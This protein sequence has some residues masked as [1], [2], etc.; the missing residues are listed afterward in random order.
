MAPGGDEEVG[1]WKSLFW[2]DAD[3]KMRIALPILMMNQGFTFL[4]FVKNFIGQMAI[5]SKK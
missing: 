2:S 4:H 3:S 5:F 1:S